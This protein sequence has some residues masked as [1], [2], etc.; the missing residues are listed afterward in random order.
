MCLYL[1]ADVTPDDELFT[2]TVNVGDTDVTIRMK[3]TG[4]KAVNEFRWLKD[5]QRNNDM[6]GLDTWTINGPVTVND[7]GVY[8]CHIDNERNQA[9]QGLMLLIVRGL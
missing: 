6:D 3:T 2:K 5:N 1:L 8:E 9:R 4:S 7:A